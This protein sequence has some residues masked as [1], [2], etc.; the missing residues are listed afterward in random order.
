MNKTVRK[1]ILILQFVAAIL[2]SLYAMD[3]SGDIISDLYVR[4]EGHY[5]PYGGLPYEYYFWELFFSGALSVVTAYILLYNIKK[6]TYIAPAMLLIPCIV[7]SLNG[8]Q[9]SG[10]PYFSYEIIMGG[11]TFVVL[12]EAISKKCF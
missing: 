9:T 2:I 10:E 5:L 6:K 1:F 3:I 4:I 11:L 8:Y 7:F 12:Y